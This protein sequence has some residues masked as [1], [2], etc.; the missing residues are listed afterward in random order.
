MNEL[1]SETLTNIALGLVT[2][3]FSYAVNWL[4][5]ASVRVKAET[6]HIKDAHQRELV[7]TALD[8]LNDVARKTVQ[9]LEQT[10]AK[11][12]RQA[13]KAGEADRSALVSLADRAK[14]DIIRTMEP[15]YTALLNETLGDL[16]AYVTST[17]EAE[18][19]R[20]KEEPAWI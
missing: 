13:I 15:E 16:S 10:A 8:R 5:K 9:A 12:L 6:E 2:L 11:E 17:I 20:L 14:R 7:Q 1:I 18:V 3:L 4:R 19:L